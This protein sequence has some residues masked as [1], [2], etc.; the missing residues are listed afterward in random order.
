MFIYSYKKGSASVAALK[1]AFDA[2]LIKLENSK[3]VGGPDKKILNWGSSVANREVEMS[4]TLNKPS[5]VGVASNKLKFFNMLAGFDITPEFTVDLNTAYDWLNDGNVVIARE[6]LTGHSAEGLEVIENQVDWDDYNHNDAKLYVKYI[7]KKA[8]F[9][10]H[11]FKGKVIDVQK[12]GTPKGMIPISYRV[13]NRNNGFIFIREGFTTPQCVKD[14]AVKAFNET[15]L[16]FG[17]IDVIYNEYREKAYVLEMNTAPGLEGITVNNYVDAIADHFKLKKNKVDV[18][19][20]LDERVNGFRLEDLIMDEEDGIDE[21][22]WPDEPDE[23]W[24]EEEAAPFE[25]EPEPARAPRIDVRQWVDIGAGG[26]GGRAG[27]DIDNN[28]I[29]EDDGNGGHRLRWH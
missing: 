2:K 26:G 27:A 24:E 28:I 23:P 21:D 11:V 10:V 15:G 1:Q 3:F 13:Q 8:E 25:P 29:V 6:K 16:D 18:Y 14:V 20:N 5:L 9:R 19:D 17:A 7:P 22:D 12:K 4:D